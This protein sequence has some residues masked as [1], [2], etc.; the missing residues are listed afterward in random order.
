LAEADERQADEAQA[1][2]LGIASDWFEK[3]QKPDNA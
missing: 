1:D 3:H 2:I